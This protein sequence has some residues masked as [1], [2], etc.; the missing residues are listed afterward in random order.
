MPFTSKNRLKGVN[1]Y[2]L[3]IISRYVNNFKLNTAT[4]TLAQRGE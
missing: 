1:M 4:K 2:K 3:E